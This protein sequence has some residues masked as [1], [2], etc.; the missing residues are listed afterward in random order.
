MNLKVLC[1]CGSKFSFDIEPVNGQMP[2]AIN[3]PTCGA[4]ATALA[5]EAIRRQSAPAAGAP[6][7][8]RVSGLR[9]SKHGDAP[10]APAAAPAAPEHNPLHG[11]AKAGECA[12]HPGYPTIEACRVCGKPICSHCMEQFGYVCSAYCRTQAEQKKIKLPR[13]KSQRKVK[14]AQAEA[15]VIRLIVAVLA[16]GAIFVGAW[17]WYRFFGSL[18]KVVYSVPVPKT[19]DEEETHFYAS[20]LGPG[21]LLTFNGTQLALQD[22]AHNQPLWTA[23]IQATPR[24]PGPD[25]AI[26]GGP[27]RGPRGLPPGGPGS[28][29]RYAM[30]PPGGAPSA[31]GNATEGQTLKRASA[32]A[33]AGG[34]AARKPGGASLN[35]IQPMANARSSPKLETSVI[36]STN[37]IWVVLSDRALRFSPENG[38]GR[39][40]VAFP[41]PVIKL[42]HDENSIM[43]VSQPDPLHKV[44]TQISLANGAVQ[45]AL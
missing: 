24:T 37:E 38:A 42:T 9:V 41:T 18:P 17:V 27:P 36:A 31:A 1:P 25:S 16:C 11:E 5:N 15:R 12:K 32:L 2:M 28:D 10:A 20:L 30:R 4:D 39:G 45:T 6:I 13:Y 33:A 14:N 22:V 3:C 21:K 44:I 26:P 34:A 40:D 35:A 29:P 23:N 43:A 8:A 7:Q 19:G